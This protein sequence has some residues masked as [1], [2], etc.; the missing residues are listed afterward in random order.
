VDAPAGAHVALD[1]PDRAIGVGD[2]LTLGD[3]PDEHLAVLGEGHD[4]RRRARAL[5]VG[6]DDRIAGLEDADDRVGG[7][8]VDADGLGHGTTPL[9]VVWGCTRKTL[10]TGP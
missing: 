4:R 8:E 3:L 10:C 5:G 9:A 6:D 1:G 7:A 2:G